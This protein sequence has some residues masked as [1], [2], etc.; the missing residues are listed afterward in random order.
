[1][2]ICSAK[3]RGLTLLEALVTLVITAM[4]AG[5]MAEGLFQLGRVE[6]RLGTGQL[7]ARLENLHVLWLQ[8]SLE[9][10]RPGEQGTTEQMQGDRRRVQGVSSLLP[11]PEH[12]G[13]LPMTLSMTYRQETGQTELSLGIGAP[14]KRLQTA[15]L[16]RWRGDAGY[17]SYLDPSGEWRPEWPPMGGNPPLLPRAIA[18]H[19]ENGALLFV[20]AMQASP[21]ALGK[22]TEIERLP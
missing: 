17:F 19:A 18:V 8:Q 3:Q 16:A 10:L 1:M 7:Q 20:A 2:T 13:P 5:L 9:G 15:V 14:D 22:R 6:Q 11:L 12:L 4:V 21:Q